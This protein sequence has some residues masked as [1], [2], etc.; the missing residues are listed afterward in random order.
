[1]S[2][3][4]TSA[5]IHLMEDEDIR[6]RPISSRVAY[7]TFAGCDLFIHK[8]GHGAAR[9]LIAALQNAIK[10]PQKCGEDERGEEQPNY[11]ASDDACDCVKC[12]ESVCSAC[13]D[14]SICDHCE[15][16]VCLD[17]QGPHGIWCAQDRADDARIEGEIDRQIEAGE[18][19]S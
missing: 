6:L 9:S 14:P 8:S 13:D 4:T 1:M 7:I 5:S 18:R 15:Q 11:H 17:C 12:G 10:P 3:N 19:T 2:E 16:P